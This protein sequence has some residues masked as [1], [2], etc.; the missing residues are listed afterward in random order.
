[1]KKIMS[2]VLTTV[3]ITLLMVSCATVKP[4]QREKLSDPIM[5]PD[6]EFTKQDLDQ[7]FFN[8]REG[9]TGGA[10]GIG[11]GCGCAK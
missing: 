9:S 5:N 7:K 2:L 8:S 1:M 4:Y 3:L 11:G 10:R 6:N